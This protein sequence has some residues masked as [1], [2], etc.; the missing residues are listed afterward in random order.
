MHSGIVRLEMLIS[1]L[2]INYIIMSLTV[3]LN[4][5]QLR[6]KGTVFLTNYPAPTAVY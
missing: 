5:N 1:Y 6:G 2:V 3:N 4:C